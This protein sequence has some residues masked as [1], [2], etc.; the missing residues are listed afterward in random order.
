ME[1]HQ[2]LGRGSNRDPEVMDIH[3]VDLGSC[4]NCTYQCFRNRCMLH[5]DPP[6]PLSLHFL[7]TLTT[8]T[9]LLKGVDVHPLIKGLGFSKPIV[10]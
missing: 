5:L 6:F 4:I 8:H 9:P 10:L 3:L 1:N 7:Q 2:T